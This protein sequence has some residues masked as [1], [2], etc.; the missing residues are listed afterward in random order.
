[1]QFQGKLLNQTWENEKKQ[2]NFGPDFG[3]FGPNLGPEELFREFYLY[4]MLHIVA[5]YH[6]ML[7]QG[8]LINQTW[9]NGKNLVLSP[10]LTPLAQI[11]ATN[12]FSKNLALSVTTYHGQLSSCTISEKTNDPVL[13]KVRDG[14]T[15]GQTEESDFIGRCPTN[16]ELP[17]SKL[18]RLF[19][20]IRAESHFPLIWSRM[21]LA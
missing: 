7:F 3:S 2:T 18:L 4:Y 13:R 14:R 15:D 20:G 17:K 21:Y 8:K 10:I 16:V 12:I 5:S 9:K 6:C 11:L 19:V 1:M